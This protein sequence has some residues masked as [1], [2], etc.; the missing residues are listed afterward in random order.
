MSG[1]LPPAI[2]QLYDP[3]RTRLPSGTE[4]RL[5]PRGV[6]LLLSVPRPDRQWVQAVHGQTGPARFAFVELPHVLVLCFRFG[7]GVKWSDSPWQAMRQVAL[8]PD[9]PPGL[10]GAD[11]PD[12]HLLIN[13]YL[14]DSTTG[15]V[16]GHGIVSW[17]PRFVTAVRAALARQQDDDAAA[18]VE[19]DQLYQRFPKVA[20]MVRNRADATCTGG[21]QHDA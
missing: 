16:A 8:Y 18:G 13:I 9:Y 19:L 20:D 5:S 1:T 14:V 17:P 2:G 12:K 4:W 10:P 21:V 3:A 6:E 15:V 7:D 11:E